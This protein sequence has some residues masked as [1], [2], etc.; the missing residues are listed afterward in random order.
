MDRLRVVILGLGDAGR[1]WL[2]AVRAHSAYELVAVADQSLDVAQPVAEACGVPAYDDYRQMLVEQSPGAAVM[3]VPPF[4]AEQYLPIAVD[5]G[6]AVLKETP[7]ARSFEDAVRVLGCFYDAQV[8]LVVA[9]R[10]RFDAP[11]LDALTGLRDLP[12]VVHASAF[13]Q[14]QRRLDWRGDLRRAGGGALLDVGYECVDLV[15]QTLGLPGDV[16]AHLARAS[17]ELGPAD[18]EQIASLFMRFDSGASA[19]IA[20]GWSTLGAEQRL[21]LCAPQREVELAERTLS[22]RQRDGDALVVRRADEPG[23]LATVLESFAATV[24]E[25]PAVYAGRA[26]DQL[27]TLAVLDAA[28]LSHRTRMAESPIRAY[29]LAGLPLPRALPGADLAAL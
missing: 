20:A 16:A 24:R 28:Y 25:K 9:A 21:R 17:G 2:A 4:V 13:R 27:A 15:V 11:L 7:L 23:M 1:R 22:V 8:P 19:A 3:A 29:E 18:T 14:L 5:A 10:W 12:S 6:V 26:A